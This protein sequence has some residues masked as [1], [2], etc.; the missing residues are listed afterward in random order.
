MEWVKEINSSLSYIEQNLSIDIDLNRVAQQAGCSKYNFERLF[1]FITGCSLVY[2][3]RKRIVDEATKDLLSGDYPVTEVA[4]KYGYNTPSSFSRTYKQIAGCS[5][6]DVLKRSV[7]LTSFTPI[8][9]KLTLKG[10]N[11]MKFKLEKEDGLILHGISREFCNADG[12]NF[13]DIPNMWSEL[14]MNGEFE[15]LT[16]TCDKNSKFKAVFGVCYAFNLECTKFKYMIGVP[17]SGDK[18]ENIEITSQLYAKFS[19]KGVKDLQE[20]TKNIFSEWLPN[21]IYEHADSP[22]LEFY[23]ENTNSDEIVCEIWIPVIKKTTK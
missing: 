8:S 7:T 21:S 9:F 20:T 12:M 3:V 6:K 23:P 13:I 4:M 11:E 2:Y 18:Y 17:G 5:P 19:C 1:S 16:K 15:K 22:E 10:S 14:C